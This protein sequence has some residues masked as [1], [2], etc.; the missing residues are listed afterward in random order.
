MLVPSG[1][2]RL[3]AKRTALGGRC[4][5]AVPGYPDVVVVHASRSLD[6][7]PFLSE[8]RQLVLEASTGGDRVPQEPGGKR[9]RVVVTITGSAGSREQ[10]EASV[11]MTDGVSV[12]KGRPDGNMLKAHVPDIAE[13]Q[14]MM[15]GPEGFMVS[16][17]GTLRALGVA[18]SAI[19][20][21]DFY[22]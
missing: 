20:S 9:L 17:E 8:M 4:R 16:M 10:Q 2:L 6:A 7:M 18:A 22:F 11:V 14:V 19:H 15:C 21:E 3:S 1:L 13:R 5:C 12:E